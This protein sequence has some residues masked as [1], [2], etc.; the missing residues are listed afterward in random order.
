M[1]NF[2]HR[3]VVQAARSQALERTVDDLMQMP[4]LYHSQQAYD[5]ADRTRSSNRHH[6]LLKY[7]R[8]HDAAAA[9]QCWR[10]H[11]TE[12]RDRILAKQVESETAHQLTA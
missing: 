6:E 5:D 8:Q 4:L 7:L 9:E 12:A 10:D 11:L 2:V 1:D 3:L